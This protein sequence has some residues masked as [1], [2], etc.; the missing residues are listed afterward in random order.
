MKT[1]K[2]FTEPTVKGFD[3]STAAACVCFL[4]SI[5]EYLKRKI[6]RVPNKKT[7]KIR[8]S[9]VLYELD[10]TVNNVCLYKKT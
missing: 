6:T 3:H 10:Y 8:Q 9:F 1:S 5:A 7:I 2:T 4:V